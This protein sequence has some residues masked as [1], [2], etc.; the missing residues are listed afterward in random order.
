[1]VRVK[2]AG[3]GGQGVQFLGKLLS[4]AAFRA[5]LNVS[6]AVIYEPATSGGLTVADVT[7]AKKGK[8][9]DYPYI[10]ENPDILLALA[11]RGWDEFKHTVGLNTIVLIDES[12]VQEFDE[13]RN[14][15]FS[16]KIPFIKSAINLGSEKAANL[17][18]LGFLAE[19]LD[20]EGFHIGA[21]EE[22]KPDDA[23]EYELLEVAPEYFEESLV[24][25]SPDNFK[26]MNK[27]AFKFGYQL[28]RD[29]NY[30]QAK[31]P[32]IDS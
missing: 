17:V 16:L 3:I 10:E 15:K 1:M 8:V 23:E 19:L 24:N 21:I 2:I 9:I 29:T 11:Q 27:K 12:T 22:S 13:P 7:I 25:M 31:I 6:Q 28:S 32:A 20:F 4:D 5:D 14:I 30:E 26:D 18:A